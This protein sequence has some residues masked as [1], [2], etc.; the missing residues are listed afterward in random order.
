[1]DDEQQRESG[2]RLEDAERLLDS[3]L[4]RVRDFTKRTT[5]L[6]REEIEDMV[7]EAKELQRREPV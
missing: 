4:D 1:M 2:V 6:A 7:T 5:A 3:L